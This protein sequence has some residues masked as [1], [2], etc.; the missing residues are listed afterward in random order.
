MFAVSEELIQK[1]LCGEGYSEELESR[2][3]DVEVTAEEGKRISDSLLLNAHKSFYQSWG[4]TA[5]R[6]IPDYISSNAFIASSYSKII[7]S[8]VKDLLWVG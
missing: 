4:P 2:I 1:M 5:W 3:K 8:Y 7:V 6:V